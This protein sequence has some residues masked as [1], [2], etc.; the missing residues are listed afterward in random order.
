MSGYGG[1]PE[2]DTSKLPDKWFRLSNGQIYPLVG[3][4]GGGSGCNKDNVD[5]GVKVGYRL[6]DTAAARRWGYRE[7]DVGEIMKQNELIA[8]GS[9]PPYWVQSKVDA[10]ELGYDPTIKAFNESLKKLHRIDSYLIHKPFNSFGE[11]QK[12]RVCPEKDRWPTG[13]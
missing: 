11:Q 4:G 5:H 6:F 12:E 10:Y 3:L 13:T 8:D 2:V 7:E 9:W 1:E